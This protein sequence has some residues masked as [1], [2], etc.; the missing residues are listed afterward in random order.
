MI[1]LEP[2]HPARPSRRRFCAS[3]CQVT[4][5]ALLAAIAEACSGGGPASP[6]APTTFSPLSQV[7]GTAVAGG[8]SVPVAASANLA[9]V[10]GAVLVLSSRGYF[11]LARTGA[12]TFIA[13]P[14]TCTHQA[15]TITEFS[16]G[17][18]ICPCH[19]S[20]FSTS[21]KV[22]AGPAFTSLRQ[23]PATLVNDTITIAV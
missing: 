7:N 16:G 13:L 17:V 8:V 11:L 14:A 20:Q 10:G 5:C 21:G 6:T 2:G 19:G 22:L 18:Y 1:D 15:C 9:T 12:D 23:L 4:S 3:A